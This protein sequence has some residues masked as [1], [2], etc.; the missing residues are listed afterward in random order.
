MKHPTVEDQLE[1]LLVQDAPRG[2][3]SF[4]RVAPPTDRRMN[5][6]CQV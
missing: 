4:K 3:R 1:K 2:K 5:R 6:D